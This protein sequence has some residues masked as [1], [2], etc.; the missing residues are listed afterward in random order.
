MVLAMLTFYGMDYKINQKLGSYHQKINATYYHCIPSIE[1]WLSLT[2]VYAGFL[3]CLN[4]CNTPGKH[5]CCEFMYLIIVSL[6]KNTV[7]QHSWLSFSFWILY[8]NIPWTWKG[9]R[10]PS[11][12]LGAASNRRAVN[13]MQNN[14][15]ILGAKKSTRG[16]GQGDREEETGWRGEIAGLS[17]YGSKF[18]GLKLTL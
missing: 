6:T 1:K 14:L 4:L 12:Q 8:L 15:E 5:D 17:Q 3:A 9:H 13:I 16:P 2:P 11:G 10:K 18:C 7:A